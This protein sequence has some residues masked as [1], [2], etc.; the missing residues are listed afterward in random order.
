M[1]LRRPTET[2]CVAATCVLLA[3]LGRDIRAQVAVR[4]GTRQDGNPR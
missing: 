2:A 3:I 1:K 4:L